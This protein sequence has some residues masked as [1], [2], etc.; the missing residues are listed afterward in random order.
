MKVRWLKNVARVKVRRFQAP[1]ALLI[2]IVFQ[3]R[4]GANLKPTTRIRL[5]ADSLSI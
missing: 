2:D 4:T 1:G 3:K 5:E